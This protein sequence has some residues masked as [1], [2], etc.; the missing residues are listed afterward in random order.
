VAN[1]QIILVVDDNSNVR[2]ESSRVLRG[3]GFQALEAASLSQA[4][5]MLTAPV[6]AV[7]IADKL[8]DGSAADLVSTLLM[9]SLVLASTTSS[10]GAAE[11]IKAGAKGSLNRQRPTDGLLAALK[12]ALTEAAP[13]APKPAKRPSNPNVRPV[14]EPV[15]LVAEPATR[16]DSAD[17]AAARVLLA[18]LEKELAF[19]KK[20]G[21]YRVLG[22]AASATTEEVRAAFERFK[23]KWH[24][25]RMS[26][27]ATAAMRS[28]ASE[29][30]ALGEQAFKVLGDPEQREKYKPP[31]TLAPKSAPKKRAAQ[32]TP[33]KPAMQPLPPMSAEEPEPVDVFSA[34]ELPPPPADDDPDVHEAREKLRKGDTAGAK[35]AIQ[36]ALTRKPASRPAAALAHVAA[37]LEKVDDADTA[38]RELDEALAED[39]NCVEA[40]AVKEGLAQKRAAVLNKISSDKISRT[41]VSEALVLVFSNSALKDVVGT[42]ALRTAINVRY[43]EMVQN[44]GVLDLRPLWDILAAQPGFSAELARAPLCRLKLWERDI[45][46]EILL[47]SALGEISI[48]EAHKH[49][50]GCKVADDALMKAL[51]GASA[52]PAPA[53]APRPIGSAGSIVVTGSESLAEQKKRGFAKYILAAAILVCVASGIY[54]FGGSAISSLSATDISTE[55]PAKD[56]KKA[57]ECVALVLPDRGWLSVPEEAREKQM[58]DALD[59]ARM[60]GAGSVVVM[61]SQEAILAQATADNGQVTVS[62]FAK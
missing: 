20:A 28:K 57:G 51:S 34:A 6:A 16:P 60:Q 48:V 11:A 33:P 23:A 41:A 45:G 50:G 35:G 56:A 29:I 47:P 5:R 40:L 10:A 54:T 55:I 37:A 22:V 44:P 13:A 32:P 8:P 1:D 62:F 18:A 24:P 3:A 25:S 49:A 19:L 17:D 15:R 31:P 14:A 2:S 7:I 59:R 26:D 27:D 46:G 38:E 30:F 4:R 12:R 58:K 9:P 43:K 36:K 21:H 52:A 53:P 42:D 39:P 61:D